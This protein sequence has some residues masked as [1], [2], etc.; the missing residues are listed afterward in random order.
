[1]NRSL[2]FFVPGLPAPG[3]S[4]RAFIPKG[5]TRP[6]LTDM[7]GKK[8]KDWRASVALAAY[9]AMND[10]STRTGQPLFDGALIFTATFVM[11][12]LKGHF[13]SRGQ[14]KANAPVWVITRP[15]TLKLARSTEDAL[16]GVVW[17]DDSQIAIEHLER[18]YGEKTGAEIKIE[19][20]SEVSPQPAKIICAAQDSLNL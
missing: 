8:N 13:N 12:R 7:G 9:H 1:M 18:I 17:R 2:S 14:L 19:T 5:W 16:T 4:K 15:D 3:G 11:P 10:A 6:V 20:L